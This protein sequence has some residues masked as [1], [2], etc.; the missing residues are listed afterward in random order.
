MSTYSP[1]DLFA[2]RYLLLEKI[3]I[4]GFSEVWKAEDQ[5]AED[6]VVAIK[7]YA[8]E[9]GMDELG[10]KQFRREYAVVLNL[11]HPSL[12]TARH[13][14][15]FNGS[16]YLVMP[17]ISG[18][19]VYN[20]LMEHGPYSEEQMAKLIAQMADAFHFL[21]DHD[22]LH[23]DIKPD[24]ILID[25]RGNYLLTD[26]GISSRLRSSLR[27]S[28]TT[29]TAMTVAYA[30]PERFQG[31]QEALAAGDIFSFGVLLY[32]LAVGD[33]PWMGAGGVVVK[34]NSEPVELS[35]D[36]SKRFQNLVQACLRFKPEDRPTASDLKAWALEFMREGA[37]PEIPQPKAQA[38]TET[39]E[40]ARGRSTQR[41]DDLP[42]VNKGNEAATLKHG[43]D[44]MPHSENGK[45]GKRGLMVAV[46]V[47]LLAG[48]ASAWYFSSGPE[49]TEVTES[50]LQKNQFDSLL[51]TADSMA[52]TSDLAAALLIYQEALK[53]FPDDSLGLASVTWC[54]E[55][56]SLLAA[57]DSTLTDTTVVASIT[58][59]G[60]V[61]KPAPPV[62]VE[63]KKVVPK[64]E[65]R[66]PTEDELRKQRLKEL[67]GQKVEKTG[68]FDLTD[69]YS[70]GSKYD[71]KGAVRSGKPHGYGIAYFD[72]GNRYEGNWE[73]GVRTG[74]GTYYFADGTVYVGGWK[75]DAFSGR[76]KMTWDDGDKY[77]G[78]YANGR[79]NGLG[80]Y[81]TGGGDINNCPDCR[82]YQGYWKDNNKHGM[83]KCFDRNG[84]LL[85]DG[86]FRDG[87]P[88]GRY[89][90]R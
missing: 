57:G 15:V 56:I 11:N 89:P 46:I 52:R 31:S 10:L 26:F 61:V 81:T 21:H 30:P 62:K 33:V 39:K 25:G 19:S 1:N 77:D 73:N 41:M 38:A 78:S 20:Q 24:N 17:F 84:K 59:P 72:D 44:D 35:G 5:M 14:D 42:P 88:V 86:E 64:V 27:K 63:E 45:K 66:K 47:L 80:T 74:S 50:M 9:R 49:K 65:E 37:W 16:P 28:T 8:P 36:Y 83:G 48:G 29:A 60:E 67:E 85:Y 87:K 82:K 75:N 7:I 54:E 4:G 18:G 55:Q 90:N 32:E 51:K 58:P 40:P 53:L 23:Q 3:G 76:G 79:R 71:Y 2:N 6:T 34:A 69:M 13:F 68:D 22:V 43:S 12:L 70:S